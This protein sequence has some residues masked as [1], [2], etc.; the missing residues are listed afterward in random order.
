MP[1]TFGVRKHPCFCLLPSTYR[2]ASSSRK[3]R[4]HMR[5]SQIR[6]EDDE[7]NQ[8]RFVEDTLKFETTNMNVHCY[9][10]VHG[11]VFL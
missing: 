4:E 10:R 5:H 9:E 8:H 6:P 1:K 2:S 11:D 7:Q 3:K